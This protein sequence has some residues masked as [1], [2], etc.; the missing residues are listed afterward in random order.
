MEKPTI[1]MKIEECIKNAYM[2]YEKKTLEQVVEILDNLKQIWLR[3]EKN[4]IDLP[5][6]LVAIRNLV[7]QYNCIDL[8][9]IGDCLSSEVI[10]LLEVG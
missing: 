3:D 6:R 2:N 9:G 1:K 4:H 10:V 8:I 5:K 7:D